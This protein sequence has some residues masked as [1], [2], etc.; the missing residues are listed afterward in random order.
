M[1]WTMAMEHYFV[2]GIPLGRHG[3]PG[4]VYF[5]DVMNMLHFDSSW[6]SFCDRNPLIPVLFWVIIYFTWDENE[7]V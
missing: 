2:L 3:D 4:A 5:M 6:L 1:E 7:I